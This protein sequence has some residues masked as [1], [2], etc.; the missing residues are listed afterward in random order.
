MRA[1]LHGRMS[2]LKLKGLTASRLK[3][4]SSIR[5]KLDRLNGNLRQLQDLGGCR[6]VV[7]SIDHAR[8]F[9]R[10]KTE[11]SPHTLK[12]VDAYMDEP[13]D[14]GYRSHSLVFALEPRDASEE[15]YSGRLIEMQIRSLLQHSW[16]T[17]VEAVGL[18]RDENL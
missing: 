2:A 1:E 11:R 6:A 15:G 16:A 5:S 14:S 10:E 17:A 13:R 8:Q 3:Q 7:L 12:G 4:M 9:V 18:C